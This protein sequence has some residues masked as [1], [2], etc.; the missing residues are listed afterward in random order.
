MAIIY[1][2]VPKAGNLSGAI[3]VEVVEGYRPGGTGPVG[4]GGYGEGLLHF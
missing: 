4:M 2:R 1:I 3:F